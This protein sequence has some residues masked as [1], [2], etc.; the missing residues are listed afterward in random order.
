M[1]AKKSKPARLSKVTYLREWGRL[2][3][4]YEGDKFASSETTAKISYQVALSRTIDPQ[5]RELFDRL[6][7][8]MHSLSKS[9]AKGLTKDEIRDRAIR[10]AAMATRIAEEGDCDYTDPNFLCK[11]PIG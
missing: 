10:V 5:N 7:E 6:Q 11:S 9:L 2:H 4:T 8:H 3:L 1:A